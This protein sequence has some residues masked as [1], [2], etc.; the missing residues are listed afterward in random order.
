M[1]VR[2]TM[3]TRLMPV[4]LCVCMVAVFITPPNQA[5]A[6]G[7][8]AANGKPL[9]DGTFKLTSPFGP[10]G[11]SMH[12]G[13]DLA[14]SEGTDIFAAMDGTVAAAG[15][16]SGFGQWI[17]VDSQTR[18]GKVSTVYGHM[19]PDGVLVRQ[20]ES[21]KEGQHIADIGNNGR[22]T[23]PHL[24][25]ELWEGGRLSQ[26]QAVDPAFVLDQPE[27]ARRSVHGPTDFRGGGLPDRSAQAWPGSAGVC[28]VAAQ[29]GRTVSG[30]YPAAA[31]RTIGGGERFP[32]RRD[33]PRVVDRR[34]RGRPSSCPARGQHGAKTLTAAAR[35]RTS[36]ASRMR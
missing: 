18:T 24:H 9:A 16:A 11:N 8:C 10:R 25:F 22:S 31:G 36:T 12:Q 35:R 4:A 6:A 21:V 23:G 30:H 26:G 20:G 13:I 32:A 5:W 17:V 33:C 34:H 3:R 14:A 29:G 27:A 1:T 19:Y 15:P 2:L 28:P 7:A